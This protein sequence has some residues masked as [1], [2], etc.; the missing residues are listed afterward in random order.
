[1]TQTTSRKISEA[2]IQKEIVKMLQ[3]E[4]VHF[5]GKIPT[6]IKD[7]PKRYTMPSYVNTKGVRIIN[8]YWRKAYSNIANSTRKPKFDTKVC[9]TIEPQQTKVVA[10]IEMVITLPGEMN[11]REFVNFLTLI[12]KSGAQLKSV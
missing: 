1:M 8:K 5:K 7:L 11:A 12:K 3:S 2:L 10:P 6:S 4:R 9:E